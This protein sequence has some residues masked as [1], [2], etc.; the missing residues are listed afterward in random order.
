VCV[1]VSVCS[2]LLICEILRLLTGSEDD[3]FYGPTTN[4]GIQ[5]SLHFH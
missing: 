2:F 5:N 3:C 1:C 4:I